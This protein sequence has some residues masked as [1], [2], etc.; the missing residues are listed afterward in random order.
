MENSLH[1]CLIEDS[2]GF[3][4]PAEHQVIRA[5][6]LR[7]LVSGEMLS[8]FVHRPAAGFPRLPALG[9]SAN[10]VVWRHPK[11]RKK[12]RC[13]TELAH[14]S[15][16]WPWSGDARPYSRRTA[17]RLPISAG[18]GSTWRSRMSKIALARPRTREA[19]RP[20]TS[21][22][23][24]TRRRCATIPSCGRWRRWDGKCSI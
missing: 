12:E 2:S 23:E 8:S 21:S 20:C 5:C 22:T 9:R 19:G 1:G 6:E 7:G 15:S 14:C 16:S 13:R 18:S 10:V 3:A 11:V 17:F 24:A 4:R